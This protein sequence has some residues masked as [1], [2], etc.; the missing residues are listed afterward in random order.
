MAWIFI[1]EHSLRT[2]KHSMCIVEHFLGITQHS[3]WYSTAFQILSWITELI[4]LS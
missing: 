3:V 2:V 1:V 4:E